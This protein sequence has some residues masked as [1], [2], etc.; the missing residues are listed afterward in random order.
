[1][2]PT[3]YLDNSVLNRPFD[4]QSQPRIAMETLAFIQILNKIQL[5][6]W[7]W[8]L[9]SVN[10]FENSVNPYA[11]RREWIDHYCQYASKR[12]GIS[13]SNQARANELTKCRIAPIDALHLAVSEKAK[14][15]FF[16]T[17]DDK[18]IKRYISLNQEMVVINPVNLIMKKEGKR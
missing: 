1:M 7:L 12:I 13:A 14:V 18:L 3:I 6:Q 11:D 4:D 8:I 15:D 2:K 17:C 10:E 9:S 16:V 5:H